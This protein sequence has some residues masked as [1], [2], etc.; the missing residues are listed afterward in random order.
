MVIST[1]EGYEWRDEST[2]VRSPPY[3]EG[4]DRQTAR[5]RPRSAEHGSWSSSATASRRITSRR[6]ARSGRTAR[7]ALPRR[8]GRDASRVQF[9]RGAPRQP[10]GDDA[11]HVCEHP[12]AQPACRRH[13]GK[14][15]LPP[16]LRRADDGSTTRRCGTEARAL[17][18]WSSRAPSTEPG[19][20]R[21]WAAKGPALLGV[22][23]VLVESIERIPPLQPHRHGGSAAPVPGRERNTGS[24]G[25]DG[26][27]I[28]IPRKG[29][30]RA[31]GQSPSS[32]PRPAEVEPEAIHR[33]G[34]DRYAEGNGT[35][36]G[37]AASSSMSSDSSRRD[38]L[39]KTSGSRLIARA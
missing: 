1:S 12:A 9:L 26:T 10:R 22:R 30:N 21:D 7:Q 18:S 17:P 2:Y 8:A 27:E 5:L 35:T 31:L 11:G 14:L 3:F 34:A 28:S 24:L 33:T 13:R 39:F 25:L 36:S 15:D 38:R 37:T 20:S 23:A 32:P 16:P 29:S 19:S 6:P 4:H